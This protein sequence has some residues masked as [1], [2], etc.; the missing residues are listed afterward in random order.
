[1]NRYLRAQLVPAIAVAAFAVP[2]VVFCW[3][4]MWEQPPPPAGRNEAIWE[5]AIVARGDR[6]I[7]SQ[8]AVTY[9]AWYNL[10]TAAL[11][12]GNLPKAAK[13]FHVCLSNAPEGSRE[14]L[15]SAV[16]MALLCDIMG[17]PELS[18][19][20]ITQFAKYHPA[21]S[22]MR[23]EVKGGWLALRRAQEAKMESRRTNPNTKETEDA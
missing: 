7:D 5:Q 13:C 18:D 20:W 2:L 17:K 14:W 1:M 22:K 21:I 9:R 23:S 12:N 4:V 16:C 8:A 6:N 11:Q 3:R 19:R 15:N 10:G